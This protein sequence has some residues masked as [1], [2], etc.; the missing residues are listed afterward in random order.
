MEADE[1]FD[2][3]TFASTTGFSI[4]PAAARNKTGAMLALL[5]ATPNGYLPT[6]LVMMA[7]SNLCSEVSEKEEIF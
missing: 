2:Y 6:V 1:L 7:Q 4:A 5:S 3:H